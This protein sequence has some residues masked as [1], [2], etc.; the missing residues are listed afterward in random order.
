[1][2]S[3]YL[4]FSNGIATRN[5]FPCILEQ[6]NLIHKKQGSLILNATFYGRVE[7]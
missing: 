6:V 2:I 4:E 3:V 1:M 7:H 5:K